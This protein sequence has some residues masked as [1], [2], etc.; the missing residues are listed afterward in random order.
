MLLDRLALGRFLRW[1]LR[2][3]LEGLAGIH[4]A[5]NEVGVN[6]FSAMFH[7]ERCHFMDDMER[8][9]SSKLLHQGSYAH[10]IFTFVLAD[11]SWFR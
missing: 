7:V 10:L 1:V 3:I 6:R 2:L 4:I 8:F 9:S 11:N 5:L